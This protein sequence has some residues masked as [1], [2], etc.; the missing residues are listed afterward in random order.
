VLIADIKAQLSAPPGIVFIDTLNRSLA[1]SESKDEDM[2]AYLA[3]AAKIE[4][5]FGCFVML[6]HHCGID[7]TRPRGHTSLTGAVDVQLAVER[8]DDRQIVLR[9]ELAKDIAE[10]AEIFSRLETVEL[11][12]DPEGDPITSFVVL[13]EEGR[14]GK[15]SVTEVKLSDNQQTM[16]SLL[17]DAGAAGLTTNE[18]NDRAREIGIGSK[19][20]ATLYDLQ[21]SLRKKKLVHRDGERW[22]AE[23]YVQ[24][25]LYE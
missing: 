20:H 5:T 21:R 12:M 23:Q 7:G 25:E 6:V 1:G 2:A 18:W 8:L 19:R 14:T 22:I 11:G 13:P 4:Q 16:V 10:G 9:V 24:G 3:A 17:Q 15:T